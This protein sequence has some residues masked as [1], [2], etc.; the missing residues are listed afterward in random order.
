MLP[1]GDVVGVVE[2]PVGPVEGLV[3]G[4]LGVTGVEPEDCGVEGVVLGES[5]E[6]DGVGDGESGFCDG[7]EP[8][9][10]P[11]PPGF[12]GAGWLCEPPLRPGSLLKTL[13]W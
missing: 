10:E 12:S 9:C 7:V 2:A 8:S 4:V 6:P 1:V 13:L 3:E 11:L 5:L